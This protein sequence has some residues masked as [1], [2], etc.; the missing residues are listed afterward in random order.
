VVAEQIG[1]RPIRADGETGRPCEIIFRDNTAL[2]F[3]VVANVICGHA[4]DRG[5]DLFRV[6]V[7]DET[8][9]RRARDRDESILGVVCE[10]EGLS[11]NVAG[12]HVTVLVIRIGV[13][14]RE[15][16][17]G[18]FVGRVV[19][20][21]DSRLA[22]K[23]PGRA[24]VAEGFGRV[25]ALRGITRRARGDETIQIVVGEG[26]RL[27]VDGIRDGQDVAY[28][29]ILIG[30]VLQRGGRERLQASALLVPG[31][32]RVGLCPSIAES[33]GLS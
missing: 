10:V 28:R 13:A 9:A 22:G 26:L 20:I 6:A 14:V 11:P 7:I 24:I 32:V 4:V 16:S 1:Q 2:H 29:V 31:I 5:L 17:D 27:R 23:I 18:V 33:G 30:V 3:V 12:G 15:R 8:R 25:T 21:V 19:S